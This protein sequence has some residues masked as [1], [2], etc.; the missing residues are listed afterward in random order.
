MSLP[1][2]P[3]YESTVVAQFFGHTHFDHLEIFYDTETFQRALSVA[4][5]APS[6]TTYDHLNPGYRVF[7]VEGPHP[8]SSW[9]RVTT[10]EINPLSKGMKTFL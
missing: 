5:I 3:R 6:V 8:N 2:F 4:Y 10:E 7:T 1:P 9:V